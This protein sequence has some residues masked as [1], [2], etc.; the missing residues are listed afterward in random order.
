MLK[1]ENG[2]SREA[3]AWDAQRDQM[4]RLYWQP[5]RTD[6][7]GA[8]G[9]RQSPRILSHVGL[10]NTAAVACRTLC[11]AW[12]VLHLSRNFQSGFAPYYWFKLTRVFQNRKA[13]AL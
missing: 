7:G 12:A 2:R 13:F 1:T 3:S 11:G 10:D 5:D 6:A 9:V 4:A 8:Q